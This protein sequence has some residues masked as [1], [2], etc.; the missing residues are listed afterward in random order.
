MVP[1]PLRHRD[2]PQLPRAR[3]GATCALQLEPHPLQEVRR[4]CAWVALRERQERR[5]HLELLPVEAR[6]L[7]GADTAVLGTGPPPE[8]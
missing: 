1:D 2:L 5:P 7:A 3:Q 6:S 8:H 4:Q